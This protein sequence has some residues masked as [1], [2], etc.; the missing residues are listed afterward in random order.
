L[1]IVKAIDKDALADTVQGMGDQAQAQHKENQA[2]YAKRQ[3]PEQETNRTQGSVGDA[4]N[5]AVLLFFDA[6]QRDNPGIKL[7]HHDDEGDD[8]ETFDVDIQGYPPKVAIAA[9]VA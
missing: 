7:Q 3:R 4:E 2:D 6:L 9:A 5:P 8:D 1:V